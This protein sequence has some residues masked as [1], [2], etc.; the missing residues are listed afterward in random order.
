MSERNT[1]Y[2]RCCALSA[3][4]D[5]FRRSRRPH[6]ENG[7]RRRDRSLARLHGGGTDAIE[8]IENKDYRYFVKIGSKEVDVHVVTVNGEKHLRTDPDETTSN[9]LDDLP[10]C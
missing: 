6:I 9:N 5:G 7:I 4:P 2:G 1:G 10:D 3:G 8:D